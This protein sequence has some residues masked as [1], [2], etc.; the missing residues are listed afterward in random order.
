[1]SSYNYE[2]TYMEIRYKQ[3]FEITRA[4]IFSIFKISMKV[5]FQKYTSPLKI[6]LSTGLRTRQKSWWF[7]Q[8]IEHFEE[9]VCGFGGELVSSFTKQA[10]DSVNI[11][12]QLSL[13]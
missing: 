5:F 10:G 1:M 13:A 9:I 2:K 3:N 6:N 4:F 12:I 8:V 7:G 11:R